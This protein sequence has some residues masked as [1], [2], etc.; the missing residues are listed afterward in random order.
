MSV[1]PARN[2]VLIVEDETN[3]AENMGAYLVAAGYEVWLAGDGSSAIAY[4]RAGFVA[5]L[6]VLD[7]DLPDMSGFEAFDALGQGGGAC[8]LVTGHPFETVGHAAAARGIGSILYKPFALV[9]LAR[10]LCRAGRP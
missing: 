9:E 5:D 10:L 1:A 6:L 2:K 3:L 4:C 7:Y 8:V